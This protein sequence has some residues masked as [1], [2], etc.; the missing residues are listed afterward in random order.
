MG[1]NNQISNMQHYVSIVQFTNVKS[2][3]GSKERT[4]VFVKDVWAALDFKGSS[5]DAEG[6]IFNINNRNYIIHQDPDITA[7]NLQD[8]AVIENGSVY[9]VTGANT[10]YLGRNKY[11]MLNCEYR[12]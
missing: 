8:L 4:Q 12:G 10:N 11:I 5:E 2:A 3:I 6:K 9:Y 1:V 7:L